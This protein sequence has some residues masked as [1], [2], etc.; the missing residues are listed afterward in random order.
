[1]EKNV[2]INLP[3]KNLEKAKKFFTGLGFGIDERFTDENAACIVISGNIYAMIITE[4]FFANFTDKEIVDASQATES[5]TSL[6]SN[7]KEEVDKIVDRAIKL[8]AT[9]NKVSEMQQG[10]SMYGRSFNDLDGHIWEII[11]MDEEKMGEE[12]EEDSDDE[13]D[14]KDSDDEET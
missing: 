2:F 13:E 7:S 10:E 1:M 5:I 14:S 8:G 4:E 6:S 12:V 9:E 11:W 3:T